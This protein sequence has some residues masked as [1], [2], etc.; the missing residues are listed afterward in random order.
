MTTYSI[1][2]THPPSDVTQTIAAQQFSQQL[3]MQGHSLNN[4]F[5]YGEGIHHANALSRV[6][7]DEHAVYQHWC[8]VQRTTNCELL[9]CI[10]A[11]V[12][13][14]VVSAEE[15]E[16]NMYNLRPPFAQAGLG[17]FFSALHECQKVVQF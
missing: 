17:E 9:V 15:A 1:L 8:E 5:F 4:V 12:K 7:S 2:I 10:T 13:R 3:C 11:A 14:G 6:P 16:D